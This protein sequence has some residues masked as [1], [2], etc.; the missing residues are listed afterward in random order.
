LLLLLL[1]LLLM[2]MMTQSG[3][4]SMPNKLSLSSR[5]SITAA[6]GIARLGGGFRVQRDLVFDAEHQLKLDWY[7]SKQAGN[8][9][10]LIIFFYGGGWMTGDKSQYLF[11][12]QALTARGYQV[13]IPNYRLYPQVKF[14]EFLT[15]AAKAVAYVQKQKNGQAKHALA[16][17]TQPTSPLFLMGHSAGGYIAAMI[18]TDPQYLA[19][20]QLDREIITAVVGIAGAYSFN[21]AETEYLPVFD[22]LQFT[23]QGFA[24]M[25][26]DTRVQT[27]QSPMLLITGGKDV[28]VM[29][30]NTDKLAAALSQV[31]SPFQLKQ[32]PQLNH[33]QLMS[34]FVKPFRSRAPV[35]ADIDAFF[36]Q[37]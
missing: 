4:Q 34:V 27:T 28:T 8:N 33:T 30:S 26:V 22:H 25:Q 7:E 19:Q 31:Q 35:V 10:P 14:P 23:Q 11:A 32:Y 3:C 21:P 37:F 2:M 20:Q 1:L 5:L 24:P 13:V 29:Q 12:A 36:R 6:N 9:S 16:K 18:A 17:N 15:D